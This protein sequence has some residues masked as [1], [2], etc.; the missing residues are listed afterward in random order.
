MSDLIVSAKAIVEP[1]RPSIRTF[2]DSGVERFVSQGH[3]AQATELVIHESVTRSTAATVRTLKDQKLSVHLIVGPDGE[4]TQHGDLLDVLWHAGPG[5]N[6]ASVGVEV[7]TP[8]YPK[9]L[10]PGDPW[11]AVI[12][13]QWADGGQY[14]VPTPAQAESLAWLTHWLTSSP[15]AGVAVPRKW[16]ALK[17]GRIQLGRI[18]GLDKAAPGVLAHTHFNHADGGWLVLYAWLR[19]EAGLAPE[20]A[21]AEAIRR[22]TGAKREAV[23]ADLV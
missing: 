3:R 2:A 14:V 4:V 11:S 18:A 5:H 22:A 9:H 1:L 10:R 20:K 6:R 23:V 8:Y 19:L 12:P 17:A 15:T 7:V 13:A 16:P 21:F